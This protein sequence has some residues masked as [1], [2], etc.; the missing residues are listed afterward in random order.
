MS[1]AMTIIIFISIF[2]AMVIT[3]SLWCAKFLGKY[4]KYEYKKEIKFGFTRKSL[5]KFGLKKYS[6]Q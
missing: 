6:E 3:L 4:E 5:E 1:I 2:I